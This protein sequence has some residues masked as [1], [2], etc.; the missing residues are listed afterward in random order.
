MAGGAE[1]AREADACDESQR[2]V[3]FDARDGAV[4]EVG[5]RVHEDRSEEHREAPLPIA[6]HAPHDASDEH[7]GHLQ[8]EQSTDGRVEVRRRNS[9]L[10][11]ALLADHAE[12]D[13]VVDVDEIAECC[14]ENRESDGARRRGLGGSC[15]RA[16]GG[17]I[18][19]GHA[20][21]SHARVLAA[22]EEGARRGRVGARP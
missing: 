3:V 4:R 14:H 19:R 15:L 22:A 6:E 21:W 12:E 1:L 17:R 2:A 7:A 9:E 8:I 11:E 18:G 13:E 16:R 10:D 5:E 20:A